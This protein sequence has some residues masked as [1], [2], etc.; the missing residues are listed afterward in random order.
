MRMEGTDKGRSVEQVD[1]N[2]VLECA[3]QAGAIL[4]ANGAEISRVEETV[5][6]MCSH[7]GVESEKAFVLSNGLFMTAGSEKEAFFARVQHIPV[8]GARLDRVTAVNQLSRQIEEGCYSIEEVRLKLDEIERMPEKSAGMK[9]LASGVGS[10]CFC[11]M[12]GGS[13]LDCA[14][15]FIAGLIL[16]IYVWKIYEPHLS[17]IIG[18]IGGG[19]L[20]SALCIL[21][22]QLHLGETMD[23]M[24]IGA[25]MPL[26][27]GIAFTNG[28]RDIADGDY[29]AGSVRL[30]DAL[31]VFVCIAAG[32][33]LVITA[34]HKL[35]GGMVL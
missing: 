29:I 32:V 1:G 4:L 20:V 30:L 19:A 15:A 24:I 13:P 17:K 7:Y 14:G 6:R 21:L 12:F 9:I 5:T 23:Q 8:R 10:G 27:P 33:G 11:L 26:V 34:Y 16:Y 22:H 28:V 2:L 18:N 25:I 31:L 35:T 3:M